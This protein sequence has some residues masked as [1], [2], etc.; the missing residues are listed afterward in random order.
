MKAIIFVCT[1]VFI[2]FSNLPAQSKNPDGKSPSFHITP[3]LDWGN[4]TLLSETDE[5]KSKLGFEFLMKI[6]VSDGI[7][8]SPFYRLKSI[9]MSV[10]QPVNNIMKEVD[11]DYNFYST[12]FTLSFYLD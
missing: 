4:H 11:S 3:S 2:L 1:F 10:R 5:F 9:G 6:P 8:I 12:G 7:T